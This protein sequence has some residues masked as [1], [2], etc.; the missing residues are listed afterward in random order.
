MS[1]RR[2]HPRTWV[3]NSAKDFGKTLAGVRRARG[4]TQQELAELT[5]MNRTYLTRLETKSDTVELQRLVLAL[6]RMGAEVT[7]TLPKGTGAEED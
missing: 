3:V 7:V 4:L 5:G 6:R 1:T 2:P